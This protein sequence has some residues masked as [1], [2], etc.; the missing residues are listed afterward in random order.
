MKFF[1]FPELICDRTAFCFFVHQSF[2]G[3]IQWM[4][5]RV[6]NT[7]QDKK[8]IT[9]TNIRLTRNRETKHFVA[10]DSHTEDNWKDGQKNTSIF[11]A[12]S[13]S[14]T[15]FPWCGSAYFGRLPFPVNNCL[16][17]DQSREIANYHS[18]TYA[19]NAPVHWPPIGQREYHITELPSP[20]QIDICPV[21]H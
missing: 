1:V 3:K 17:I 12:I 7:F 21:T 13:R 11:A 8:S 4:I 20:M 5:T 10:H 9:C 6:R 15:V 14:Q 2:V 18:C 16:S 19:I